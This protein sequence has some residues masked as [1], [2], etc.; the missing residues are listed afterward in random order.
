M[1]GDE[2]Q[3]ISLRDDFYRDGY[4]KTL[5]AAGVLLIAIALLVSASLYLKLSKPH[6]VVFAT[7]DEFRTLIPV[8]VMKPYVSQADLIQWVSEALPTAFIFD[9]INYDQQ[10][11]NISQ[12]FTVNGWKTYT[13]QLK[14]YVD[15]NT[16]VA[17]KLFTDATPAGAPFILNQGLLP[18]NIY[19]WQVQMPVNLQYSSVNR[20]DR[21]PLVLQA[22]VVR[23]PTLNNLSGLAIDKLIITQGTGDQIISNG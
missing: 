4:Y 1:A 20:G 9:F 14:Q 10:L 8:P 5:A 18:G 11:K 23:I 16:F 21:I 6:P 7:G 13:D 2:L 12:Y 17:R 19:G 22:L 3:F 15:Y